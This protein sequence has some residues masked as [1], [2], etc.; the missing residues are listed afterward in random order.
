MIEESIL[1][2]AKPKKVWRLWQESHQ[3]DRK[4]GSFKVGQ[5]GHAYSDKRKGSAFK[6]VSIEKNVS[7][8]LEWRAPLVKIYMSHRVEPHE[9]GSKIIYTFNLKGGL[10][11]ILRPFLK[12]KIR[13]HL[14]QALN[15]FVAVLEG[16]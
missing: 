13:K 4:Q 5:T 9:R 11:Y 14:K 3:W 8:T 1:S 6:I 12:K 16:S 10:S 7:F 15:E 2:R